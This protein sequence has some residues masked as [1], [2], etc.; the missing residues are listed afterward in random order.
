M[1]VD[2]SSVYHFHQ[3]FR[4]G[5]ALYDCLQRRLIAFG[6]DGGDVVAQTES[7]SLQGG[8]EFVAVVGHVIVE[9][10]DAPVQ[11]TH[12]LHNRLRNETALDEILQQTLSYPLR[13]LDIALATRK[14]LDE[15]W[16]YE[17]QFH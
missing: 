15:V 3:F 13:I 16:I 5:Y 17:L 2:G 1:L 7:T 11:L 10:H 9:I 12:I 4:I 14:L 8:V 6:F